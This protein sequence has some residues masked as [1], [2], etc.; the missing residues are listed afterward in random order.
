M[1]KKSLFL[2]DLRI[3]L[4]HKHLRIAAAILLII[5]VLYAGMFLAG[6]WNPYA[7]LDKL[8]VAVVNLDQGAEISGQKL[9][10]GGDLVAE[11][12]RSKS[13]DYR[14]VTGEKAEDGL[15]SGDYYLSIVIP[16]DF[17]KNVAS[18]NGDEPKQAEL[19]YRTNP[20]NNFVSGQIGSSAVKELKEKVSENIVKT[21]TET[22]MASIRKLSDG[23]AEAGQGATRLSEGAESAKN[24]A[25]RLQ[26]GI[27]SL[28]NGAYRLADGLAPLASGMKSLSS[29]VSELKQ[30]SASLADGLAKL[31]P[32]QSQ[33]ASSSAELDQGI[34]QLSSSLS[35]QKKQLA[36]A[37]SE[38][39]KLSEALKQFAD[40]HPDLAGDE[41]LAA[42]LS[43]SGQLAT[44]S[45]GSP[46][47]AERLA[48]QAVTLGVGHAKIT[49]GL[50]SVGVGLEASA[51][52]AAKLAAGTNGFASGM[53]SWNQGFTRFSAGLQ[54]LADNSSLLDSGAEQLA[55]GFVGLVNGSKE[56]AGKLTDA[57]AQSAVAGAG[58]EMLDMFAQPV[59]LVEQPTTDVPN[60][61]TGSAPYFLALGLM[62]G[63][64]MAFNIIPFKLPGSPRVSGWKFALSKLGLFYTVSVVQTIIVNLLLRF[65]F[66]IHP[67][68]LSL[69]LLYSLFVSMMFMT[70]LM[71]LVTVIGNLGKL[72]GVAL[73]VAQLSASGGTFPMELAD[74]WLQALGS[75]LPMTYVLRGFHA[76]ISTGE[77]SIFWKEFGIVLLYLAGFALIVYLRIRSQAKSGKLY[78]SPAGAH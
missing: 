45:A 62:V 41:Q 50:K 74:G 64:L 75:C 13:F 40:S 4:N 58:D 44:D 12:E 15:A 3:I 47:S 73:L 61:G 42:L 46:A 22:V 8:P 57:A 54:S 39:Q 9:D 60:Y 51:D 32:A 66:G 29:G 34:A 52:G 55:Q 10:A 18:L 37:S 70:L 76:V 21:Y 24:G 71:M 11:L 30:G 17:S 5:P 20:G 36:S 28:K 23:F 38:A 69:M 7:K 26:E 49:A 25:D 63:A 56:L 16:E 77:W 35:E 2:H 1:H 48:E 31:E 68:N 43:E 72:V 67:A 78:E 65:A 33:L 19:I 59:R 53:S 27:G 6:Y 14:Y